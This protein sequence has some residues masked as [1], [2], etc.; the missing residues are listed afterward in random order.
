MKSSWFFGKR[1]DRRHYI[2]I[3]DC[4]D[5]KYYVGITGYLIS[6]IYQHVSGNGAKYTQKYLPCNLVHLEIADSFG[7]AEV[8]EVF[9]RRLVKKG[10]RDF[11]L[12]DECS[13][14]FYRIAAMASRD[15]KNLLLP[16]IYSQYSQEIC[17]QLISFPFV[18]EWDHV[19]P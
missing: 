6:R 5:D 12:P 2:Y 14:L 19:I 10:W 7:H 4:S 15:D 13:D 16:L 3:L 17:N 8:I 18:T 11:Y 9:L 1:K